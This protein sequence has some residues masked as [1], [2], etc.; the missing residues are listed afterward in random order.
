M[1]KQ[2]LF[3][4]S[5]WLFII[6]AFCKHN[7]LTDAAIVFATVS[8]QSSLIAAAINQGREGGK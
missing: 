2:G 1:S 5:I 6:A 7:G 3:F 8:L 4:G